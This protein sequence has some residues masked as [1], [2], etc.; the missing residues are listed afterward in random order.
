MPLSKLLCV[1]VQN[2]TWNDLAGQAPIEGGADRSSATFFSPLR[3]SL[4][5]NAAASRQRDLGPNTLN[6][7]RS[8][9]ASREPGALRS[10]GGQAPL[11]GPPAAGGGWAESGGV[12]ATGAAHS[13]PL[14]AAMGGRDLSA[15]G[16]AA[17]ARAG[18]IRGAASDEAAAAGAEVGGDATALGPA[19]HAGA[20]IEA[21]TSQVNSGAV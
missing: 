10:S 17:A 4:R 19:A 18:A 7:G 1:Q 8:L 13:Q 5:A 14:Q 20:P 6:R 15:A 12:R 16:G 2:P 3:E 11:G 9:D 21:R